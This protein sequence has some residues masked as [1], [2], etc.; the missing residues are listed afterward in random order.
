MKKLLLSL[1]ALVVAISMNAQY[2]VGDYIFTATAKYKVTEIVDVPQ[3]GTAWTGYSSEIFSPYTAETEDDFDGIKSTRSDEG[4]KISYA[5]PLEYGTNYIVT[6][7]FMAAASGTTS[8]TDNGQNQIDA[9]VSPQDDSG[10][11]SGAAN[12]DYQ[13]VASTAT[14]T[15]NEWTEISWAF[16]DTLAVNAELEQPGG[17]LNIL[18]SRINTD[19]VIASNLQVVKVVEVYD[20]RISDRLVAYAKRLM[21]DPNFNTEAAADKRAE[22]EG[23][24][25]YTEEMAATGGLDNLG[26]AEEF[27]S[28][29]TDMLNEYLDV[30]TKDMKDYLK[31][32]DITS[33]GT[34]GRGRVNTD[35]GCFRALGGNWGSNTAW[36]YLMSAIQTGYSN[37]NA[38]LTIF[39]TDFPAGKYFFTAEL[40]NANTAKD[41]W[42]C[43]LSFNLTTYGTTM[44][45]GD[46]TIEVD[47]LSGEQFQKFY[48]VGNVAEDGAFEAQVYWPGQA[49]GVNGGAFQVRALQVRAFG[50]VEAQIHRTQ[51]WNAFITQWNAATSARTSL[52]SKK[53]DPNYP[54]ANDTI[55]TT[56]DKWDPYYNAVIAAG[57]VGEDGSDTGVAT[58]EELEDWTKYQGYEEVTV[59]A[60]GNE[61]RVEYAV[62][63]G[64]Q[65]ANNYVQAENQILFDTQSAIDAA[66]KTNEDAMNIEGDHATYEAVIKQVQ[67]LLNDILANTSD[68]AAE[69]DKARLAEAIA[70][71]DDATIAFKESAVLTPIVD[72]DFSG[73]FQTTVDP[74]DE[75]IITSYYIDGKTESYPNGSGRMVF[76]NPNN[77]QP[78]PTLQEAG[79]FWQLGYNDVLLD[80]LRVGGGANS[81]GIVEIAAEDIAT[82]EEVNRFEFD[83]WFGNLSKGYLTV[84]MQNAEGTRLGGFSIDRYNGNVAFNTF[85]NQTGEDNDLTSS[86]TNGGT[87]M[88]LRAK[89]SGIGSS[90]E[91]NAV[92]CVDNNKSTFTLIFDYKA[93]ALQG[94]INNAKNGISEGAEVPMLEINDATI[95]DNKVA[96]FVIYSNYASANTNAPGRRCWFDNLKIYKYKSTAEGPHFEPKASLKGDVNE[97]GAVNI[98]DVVAIINVMAGTAEWPNANVNEDPEGSVDINDVVAVI[99]IMA[100]K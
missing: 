66:N 26:D 87:G 63:R 71:L 39:N 13:Q 59:D 22:L 100:G 40:R 89:A 86:S 50:E 49:N 27:M 58:I 37:H 30:E 99:N 28:G 7:K 72:I 8:I 60:D 19:C 80:V 82:D 69:A 54:W 35:R 55:Q 21:D 75:S 3:P 33:F 24:V 14:I 51:A 41:S 10:Q 45:V 6:F 9:W 90:K 53:D 85:N 68:D 32:I 4:D 61:T 44:R 31:Y 98:N 92:I 38:T 74:E 43:T 23:A 15:A 48:V 79:H 20:T 1:C 64:Y 42:P 2:N 18:F 94:T 12:I 17:F 70:A 97:D 81:N 47:T 76:D 56:L 83:L 11:R 29:L 57:W 95:T 93:K 78:N 77:V 91:Q 67:D 65:Y 52:V 46:T 73:S 96:K 36:D 34:Y 25:A 84:E 88:D 16:A 62:V 5:L